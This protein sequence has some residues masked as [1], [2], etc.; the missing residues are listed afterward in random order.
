MVPVGTTVE[1][2][3]FDSCGSGPLGNRFS[4]GF[5]PR[6]GCRPTSACRKASCPTTR[7]RPA[8]DRPD[9]RQS[10]QKC[11]CGC[12]RRSSAAVRA[13]RE[14]ACA[15]EMPAAAAALRV[16]WNGPWL[17]ESRVE[18][19]EQTCS[20][21]RLSTLSSRL[22][23]VAVLP[24]LRRTCSPSYRMPLPLYGSGLRTA[25]TSAANCP[26]C[27]LSVPLMTMCVWSG[28]VTFKP[29]GIFL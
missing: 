1:A 28:Q 5:A 2:H 25:R 11:A 20:G 12:G 6:S 17:W 16:V 13:C 4:Y 8:F 9:R 29:L 21:S 14:P 23:Y 24:A 19:R 26:T 27:C 22:S 18:S 3:G 10:V 15:R 7:R